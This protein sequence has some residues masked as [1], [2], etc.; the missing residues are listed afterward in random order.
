LPDDVEKITDATN[1][2]SPPI[3][4]TAKLILVRNKDKAAPNLLLNID[5]F[6]SSAELWAGALVGI[7]L[8][9]GVLLYS[10][11]ITYH[12]ALM[13]P[14]GDAPITGYAYPCTA[15]G[16]ILLVTGLLICSHV[17]ESSTREEFYEPRGSEARM[18]YL[19]KTGTV[20]DQSFGSFAI[21]AKEGK[22]VIATSRREQISATHEITTVFATLISLSG[23]VVQFVGLRSMHWSAT[24]AQLGV[25]IAMTILRAIVRRDLVTTPTARKLSPSIELDWLA[26]N[27]ALKFFPGLPRT[28]NTEEVAPPPSSRPPN[29]GNTNRS[30]TGKREEAKM[31][32]TTSSSEWLE[33]PPGCGNADAKD[34]PAQSWLVRT[35]PTSRTPDSE[36]LGAST[37]HY[38][39]RLRK[40]LADLA[41]WPKP[42]S[43][44][45]R[46]VATAI[47][48]TLNFLDDLSAFSP[49]AETSEAG[50]DG[51]PDLTKRLTW[52]VDT[53]QHG[54]IY[55]TVHKSDSG[56]KADETEIEAAL[57][58]WNYSAHIHESETSPAQAPGL[59]DT[60][61]PK[62]DAAPR[63]ILR[64][65]GVNSARLRRD[66]RWW[67]PNETI[68]VMAVSRTREQAEVAAHSTLDRNYHGII[69]C[70]PSHCSPGWTEPLCYRAMEL[71]RPFNTT[72]PLEPQDIFLATVSEQPARLPFS[73]HL[74]TAFMWALAEKLRRPLQGRANVQASDLSQLETP[75]SWQKFTLQ[76]LHLSRL[77]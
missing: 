14:K 68:K 2:A 11:F 46:A 63:R 50:S 12:P 15:I 72:F 22:S 36:N 61:L 6:S 21:F 44:E 32:G 17:V 71:Q 19:Q 33:M 43:A 45:A 28:R 55:F 47:E 42:F 16:T 77:A 60:S 74:F 24:V 53:V 65:L 64:F 73:Q 58:L 54:M 57:S 9:F 70:G 66:L 7:V 30:A 37:A 27:L 62:G 75:L 26:T 3:P 31:H 23:F 35:I 38:A 41:P 29:H 76:N 5:R 51:D 48:S 8:Q 1:D 69:G 13:F 59:D 40:G 25:T 67:L 34:L 39:M 4:T 56:W 10:A 18:V 52:H 20:G 49:L